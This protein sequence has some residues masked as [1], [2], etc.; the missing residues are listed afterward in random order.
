MEICGRLKR[1]ITE[2]RP[3]KMYIDCIGIGAGVVDRMQEMGY[4]CVEGVNVARSANDKEK[5]RNLRAELYSDLR[6]WLSGEL[7]VQIPDDDI[8]HGELTSFGFKFT[9][10]GQLQ[11][12]SKDDLRARGMPSPDIS[13]ALMISMYGGQFG[14][15]GRR[16]EVDKRWPGEERMFS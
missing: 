8:L 10:S 15:P 9:S 7:P 11:I 14:G 1:I 6:D 12:E 16:F 5:F 4:D 13:D 3:T 2:E